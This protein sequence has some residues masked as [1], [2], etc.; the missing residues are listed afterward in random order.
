LIVARELDGAGAPG[1]HRAGMKRA[2]WAE[3][4]VWAGATV[5]TLGGCTLVAGLD[6]DV[7]LASGTGGE[8]ATASATAVST[9]VASGTATGGV[10][11]VAANDCPA[12]GP[13]GTHACLTGQCVA[14]IVNEGAQIPDAVGNCQK[15]QCMGGAPVTSADPGD[16]AEDGNLCTIDACGADGPTHVPGNDGASCGSSG[17]HCV[18]GLCLE[19]ADASQCPQGA[20][21]CTVASCAGGICGLVPAAEGA[22]CASASSCKDAGSCAGGVCVQPSKS[23][24][25]GCL[26]VGMCAGGVCCLQAVCGNGDVCCGIGQFCSAGQICKP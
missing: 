16:F 9:G 12:D 7:H 4:S 2:S 11:C 3:L 1:K 14:T 21:P 25:A 23:N 6:K 26:G 22:S 20:D 17:S 18:S 10:A 19:C 15:T 13:C 24:G 8:A 5:L